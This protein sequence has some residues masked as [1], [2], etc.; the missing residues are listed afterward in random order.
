MK[1]QPIIDS[2]GRRWVW[3]CGWRP[4]RHRPWQKPFALGHQTF[5]DWRK[6]L[7][8]KNYFGSRSSEDCWRR[9]H[10]AA[11]IHSWDGGD[12]GYGSVTV[13]STD[14]IHAIVL[15]V[16]G[17]RLEVQ[18]SNLRPHPK[19]KNANGTVSKPKM[20]DEEKAAR[21]EL[22]TLGIKKPT[23]EQLN[24]ALD[25]VNERREHLAGLFK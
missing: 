7:Q 9:L 18:L 6:G 11:M 20:S 14:G 19:P 10:G 1:L 8:D 12:Q 5:N 16:D 17:T 2:T 22:R 23:A 24:I 25:L 15:D 3:N 4:E 13:L 21:K